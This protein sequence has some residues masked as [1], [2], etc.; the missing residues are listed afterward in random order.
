MT[1]KAKLKTD[2]RGIASILVTLIIM[3]IISL[4]VVGFARLSRREQRQALDDQ[5]STQAFYAAES[6]VNDVVKRLSGVTVQPS[7]A[8]TCSGPGSFIEYLGS[9]GVSNTLDAGNSVKYTCL[10]IDRAPGDLQKSVDTEH[11]Q[12]V[13]VKP[14]SGAIDSITIAW[15][16]DSPVS[17]DTFC[18]TV[19]QFPPAGQWQSPPYKCKVGGLRTDILPGASIGSRAS[20]NSRVMTALLY[21]AKTGASNPSS[22]AVG[23]LNYNADNNGAIVSGNCALGSTPYCSVTINLLS[24]QPQVYL[25]LRSL[26]LSS[27]VIITAKSGGTNASL[28]GDQ[29]V[30]DATGKAN[31]VLRR[32]Q[33]RVPLNGGGSLPEFAILS[34]DSLCKRLQIDRTTSEASTDTPATPA[35]DILNP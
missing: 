11:S 6:G 5:L 2:Q 34:S 27:R 9:Q 32:I 3:L 18:E 7:Y 30:V 20:L 35:C 26:Y 16:N 25:R 4:I 29:A 28:V 31:D 24:A 33:V 19:G 21:P 22:Y 23:S 12:V 13:L 14:Q 8:T 10:L 1:K 17:T 15:Q